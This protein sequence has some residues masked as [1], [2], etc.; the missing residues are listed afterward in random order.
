MIACGTPNRVIRSRA[1]SGVSD[2]K[3][4]SL[5]RASARIATCSVKVSDRGP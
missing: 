5:P 3:V 2:T 1:C 4:I